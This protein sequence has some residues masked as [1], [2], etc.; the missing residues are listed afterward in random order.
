MKAFYFIDSSE[1]FAE[2]VV[3]F[4]ERGFIWCGVATREGSLHA[5]VV[6]ALL[7]SSR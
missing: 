5:V 7:S 1:P 3:A 4:R 6:T 2:N